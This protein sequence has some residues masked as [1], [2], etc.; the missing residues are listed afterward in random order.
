M[1][2]LR[3]LFETIRVYVG[4]PLSLGQNQPSTADALAQRYGSRF[5]VWEALS[6]ND[7]SVIVKDTDIDFVAVRWE[8]KIHQLHNLL[9]SFSRDLSPVFFEIHF[10][11]VLVSSSKRHSPFFPELAGGKA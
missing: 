7:A 9:V 6:L 8:R 10:A 2:C 11:S 5:R 1:L 3:R 4:G